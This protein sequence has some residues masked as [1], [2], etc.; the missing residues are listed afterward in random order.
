[1]SRA[2]RGARGNRAERAVE[3]TADPQNL[4]WVMPAE[5]CVSNELTVVVAGGPAPDPEAASTVPRGAVVI[6]ADGGLV[7]VVD[8]SLAS[9]FAPIAILR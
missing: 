7:R 8:S 6:A 2:L 1:M 3:R 9:G 5:E 4:T